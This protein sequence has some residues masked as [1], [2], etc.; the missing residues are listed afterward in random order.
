MDSDVE[1]TE[2]QFGGITISDK[3]PFKEVQNLQHESPM[4]S[5]PQRKD[6][7]TS[8]SDADHQVDEQVMFNKLV[9]R[10]KKL[11]S[12]GQVDRALE[13]N[14]RAL[15]IHYTEKLAKRIKKMEAYLAQYGGGSSEEEEDGT[16]EHLGQ[17]FYLYREFYEKLYMHQKEGL[18]WFWDLYR[19]KKGGILGDDMG[20]GKTI[21]VIGFLSG[22]FDMDK[23]KSVLIVM[24]VSVVGNWEKEFSKWAPGIRVTLYHGT[25]KREKERALA[26]VQRRSGVCL[27]SYGLVVTSSEQLSQRDKSEFVW[28]YVIL[29]EGHKIKNPTK[30][31]KGVHAIPARNRIILTGTPVQNNLREL[32]AL[33]DFVHQ[34]QLLG[35]SRTF[36]MEYENPIIRSRE[37][38]ATAGERRL[39]QEMAESLK[40]IIEPYFLRRTKAEVTDKKNQGEQKAE[41]G[42]K[43]LTKMPS[44]GRKND[45]VVWVF[46]TQTQLKIYEDFLALDSVKELLMTS[47]SPL[48]ALTVLKKIC[49]H[50]RLLSTKACAQLG[51]DGEDGLN[52]TDYSPSG[53][54]CAA[55]KINHIDDE[56]LIGE[57]GKLLVLVDLLDNL[58][59]EGH[60][61]LVFSQSR[62]L[63]DIIQ[64]VVTNR[65]HKV[66]R[67]D[68][69]I[70]QLCD[71]DQRIQKFQTDSSFSVFLLTTQVGGMGLTLTSADR[72]VIYDPSWNPATDAQAVD[73]VFRIGQ[74]KN[75][76][77]YR[78]I[79]CG[80]VE[81]K[82]YRRQI[83]KDSIT[84][85]TTGNSK[86]PYRYF[87]KGELREL[88]TLDDARFSK[89]QRQ[90][91]DMHGVDR[92]SDPRLDTHIAYLHSL[93]IF[94]V[95]DH[96]L[97]FSQEHANDVD[98]DAE[99]DTKAAHSNDYIQHRVQKAQ[100]LLQM[101]SSLSSTL[102]ERMGKYPRNCD[103][104]NRAQLR[105]S[106]TGFFQP[107]QYEQKPNRPKGSSDYDSDVPLPATVDLTVMDDDDDDDDDDDEPVEVQDSPVKVKEERA[108]VLQNQNGLDSS[109]IEILDSPVK[110][111][112]EY[113]PPDV[114]VE[115]SA[116]KTEVKVEGLAVKTEVK[117]EGSGL[118]TEV[119]VEHTSIHDENKS[120]SDEGS[121]KYEAD[122]SMTE[123]DVPSPNK[124][125][126]RKNT[127]PA[128]DNTEY[129]SCEEEIS[130]E[131]DTVM[132]NHLDAHQSNAKDTLSNE[133]DDVIDRIDQNMSITIQP[134]SDAGADDKTS[135]LDCS[136]MN[137]T[138]ERLEDYLSSSDK[139]TE[140]ID[141]IDEGLTTNK[142]EVPE[143]L[144]VK[145]ELTSPKEFKYK[146]LTPFKKRPL[147]VE[148]QILI[149]PEPASPLM[150]LKAKRQRNYSKSASP[151]QFLSRTLM[152]C[153]SDSPESQSSTS[154]VHSD[155]LEETYVD[156]SPP[157]RKKLQESLEGAGLP[158]IKALDS[159]KNIHVVE[160][161]ENTP[162]V[163]EGDSRVES[164]IC[165]DD[166]VRD[167]DE[168][169][170]V[171]KNRRRSV[172]K[173]NIV[174]ESSDEE[175]E[176]Q[177]SSSDELAE[178]SEMRLPDL[179][180]EGDELPD[181][182]AEDSRG[183]AAARGEVRGTRRGKESVLS[184]ENGLSE[185]E[186]SDVEKS[187]ISEEEEA[188]AG[189]AD[190][191]D[192][193]GSEEEEEEEDEADSDDD[194]FIDDDDDD[195]LEE[196]GDEEEGS[197]TSDEE[198]DDD[199]LDA[200]SPRLR[201][202]FNKFVQRGR[203]LY[204]EGQH[205]EALANILQAL[206]IHSDSALQAMALKMHQDLAS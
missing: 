56:V 61:C 173:R 88:F 137:A 73:R 105:K 91:Q 39:G 58:K 53:M 95:S 163:E 92:R 93:E 156:D 21:Q 181:L 162:V 84:R 86:N 64:K 49:D 124:D 76:V 66:M 85:Q 183:P 109:L 99:H 165:D 153:A 197:D 19:K 38:D 128:S 187:L 36:K 32:W 83:F 116:V 79:T 24:P 119:K 28:D 146:K 126:I 174:I 7:H 133:I 193:E 29:D 20:L 131:A 190:D 201:S 166:I 108:P 77:I 140:L 169:T 78:M 75:V 150:E 175:G 129:K 101:E 103:V 139:E 68:G 191:C 67:L 203:T 164:S 51:L 149:S 195:D 98:S 26:K 160:S 80:S 52:D 196:T 72:V 179:D 16:M 180:S 138:C 145:E 81:E 25:S 69:T 199:D 1:N 9:T 47:K 151:A 148:E 30:T 188:E 31:T 23:I 48:V 94:G 110:V 45:L 167:S 10:A 189:P 97:M 142:P 13:F 11:A 143:L 186:E 134:D 34:G 27:T 170:P 35:T 200:L 43:E 55:N 54:E 33:F 96:D 6:S 202:Q 172:C 130:S 159:L 144:T 42:K 112:S 37:R 100:E 3:R 74:N 120:Q 40:K 171:K 147:V 82:I 141:D 15:K 184:S 198:E 157:C 60:R 135:G 161:V 158:G 136:Q 168:E 41:D 22:M 4:S 121:D 122:V 87:T 206:E 44:L 114:K 8:G 182:G 204:L 111:K 123:N 46:L 125:V 132:N 185:A 107:K 71:R 12:H 113:L 155:R 5:K 59:S 104:N 102:Q 70:T 57:S 192:A 50:P 194:D 2:R 115:R 154:S 65:G 127:S 152:S 178:N 17:G 89:T 14:K 117:V 62:K 63:L 176:E 205:G 118:K 18:L 106:P 177:R 90:L